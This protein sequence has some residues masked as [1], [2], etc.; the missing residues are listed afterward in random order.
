MKKFCKPIAVRR[1]DR[2]GREIIFPS[3]GAASR[4]SDTS[5]A[6]I[7]THANKEDWIN[8]SYRFELLTEEEQEIWEEENKVKTKGFIYTDDAEDMKSYVGKHST[9][10]STKKIAEKLGITTKEVERLHQEWLDDRKE[11]GDWA[12]YQLKD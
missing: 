7:R 11:R 10:M 3:I 8:D 4:V 1:I 9:S 12:H 2:K 6:T 5:P